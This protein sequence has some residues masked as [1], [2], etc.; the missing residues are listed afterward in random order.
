MHLAWRHSLGGNLSQ[1][2]QGAEGVSGLRCAGTAGR[3]FRVGCGGEWDHI[4]FSR[5]AMSSQS[6][7]QAPAP[8]QGSH[9]VLGIPAQVWVCSG[10]SSIF[11]N[12]VLACPLG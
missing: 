3:C 2:A 6:P 12:L 10:V 5:G 4:V 7:P 11:P 9:V 8:A 1:T